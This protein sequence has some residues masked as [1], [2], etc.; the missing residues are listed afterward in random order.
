MAK[1]HRRSDRNG[2]NTADDRQIS[3][4]RVT[5]VFLVIKKHMS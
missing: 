1:E 4:K 3:K 2:L 5:F